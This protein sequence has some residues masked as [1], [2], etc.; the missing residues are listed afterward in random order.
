MRP[1]RIDHHGLQ[2]VLTTL[3]IGCLIRALE[4][5]GFRAAVGLGLVGGASLAIGLEALPFLGAATVI[6][7]LVWVLRGG[8]AATALA[9]FGAVLAGTAF[10]LIPL[11][12]VPAEWTAIVCDRMSLAHVAITAIV[13]AAGVRLGGLSPAISGGRSMALMMPVFMLRLPLS[14]ELFRGAGERVFPA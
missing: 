7:S 6:L 14:R 10:S 8:T 9:I 13:L 4:P 5:G 11:S 12:L 3:G 1:G 2:L